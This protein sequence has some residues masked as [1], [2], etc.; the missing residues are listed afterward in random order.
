MDQRGENPPATQET[1]ETRVRSLR[2]EDP[3]EEGMVTPSSTPA[4]RIPWTEKPGGATAH[5]VTE[6]R[7]Q[8]H[9]HI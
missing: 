3:L 8:L 7:T 4:W 9:T 6:S 1:Q 5:G 2:G